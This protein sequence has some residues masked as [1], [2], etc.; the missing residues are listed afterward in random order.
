MKLEPKFIGVLDW[1][2]TDYPT[3]ECLHCGKHIPSS[4]IQTPPLFC[5]GNCEH[6]FEQMARDCA[7]DQEAE[8]RSAL[9]A[10]GVK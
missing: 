8:R 2:G 9:S 3:Y 5:E 10:I 7:A 6:E 1:H 4:P